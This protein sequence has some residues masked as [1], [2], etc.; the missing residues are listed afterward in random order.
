VTSE[1]HAV[2]GHSQ[3]GTDELQQK[4]DILVQRLAESSRRE[5]DLTDRVHELVVRKDMLEQKTQHMEKLL[6]KDKPGSLQNVSVCRRFN[7]LQHVGILH[8]LNNVTYDSA[9]LFFVPQ[10][11]FV[12]LFLG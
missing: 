10:A 5:Q 4:V 7:F 3:S 1:D 11:T 12:C 6:T 2:R 8:A 9:P